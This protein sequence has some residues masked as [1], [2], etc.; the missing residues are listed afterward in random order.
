M[1]PSFVINAV[2]TDT[3]TSTTELNS[4]AQVR[5][6]SDPKGGIGLE[7]LLDSNTEVGAGT[8]KLDDRNNIRPMSTHFHV[9]LG[10]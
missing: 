4:T 2:F 8:A 5:V 6:T 3:G 7:M 1:N 10:K 9:A